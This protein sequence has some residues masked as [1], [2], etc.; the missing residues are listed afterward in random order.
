LSG[1]NQRWQTQQG[2]FRATG[3]MIHHP[4]AAR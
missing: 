2:R 1:R 4:H 3:M